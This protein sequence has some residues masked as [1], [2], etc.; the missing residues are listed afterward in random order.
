[1]GQNTVAEENSGSSGLCAE[2]QPPLYGLSP[3]PPD[4]ITLKK[5]T[6]DYL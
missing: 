1:M 5:A 4:S 3:F 6:R 2:V